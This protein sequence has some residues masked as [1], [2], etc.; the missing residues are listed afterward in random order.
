MKNKLSDRWISLLNIHINQEN[1]DSCSK[2]LS[3]YINLFDFNLISKIFN[4]F[5][6][7]ILFKVFLLN[8]CSV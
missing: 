3:K 4:Y 5:S 6:D 8:F 2:I 7:Y 1:F